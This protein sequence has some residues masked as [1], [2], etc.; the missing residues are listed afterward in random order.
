MKM[1]LM[2]HFA[3]LRR[4]VLWTLVIFVFAFGLGWI[5]AP[6]VENF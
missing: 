5:V 1:T 3:E 4:R 2:Q 6:I